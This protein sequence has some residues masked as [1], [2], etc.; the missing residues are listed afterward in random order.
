MSDKLTITNEIAYNSTFRSEKVRSQFDI[1]PKNKLTNS[2]TLD[3]SLPTKWTIGAIAGPSGSGKT[4]LAKDKFTDADLFDGTKPVIDWPENKSII[5]GFPDSESV[6]DITESLSRVGFSSPPHWLQPYHTLST[7][8]RFRVDMARLLIENSDQISIVDEFTS[9]VDRDVAK[10]ISHATAKY[11]RANS[12]TFVACSCHYDILNWLEPDWVVDLETEEVFTDPPF[13]K[14][15]IEIEVEPVE[16]SAWRLFQDHHYLD[17]SLNPSTQCYVGYWD[18]NPV[19]FVGVIHFPHKSTSKFKR[20]TRFVTLPPFQGLGIGTNVLNSV[21]DYYRREQKHRI[22]IVTSHPGLMYTLNKSVKWRV[23]DS[24]T[25]NAKHAGDSKKQSMNKT[26][27][28][29]RKTATFEY[30]GGHK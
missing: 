15:Q 13:Q 1:Q 26:K 10:S 9:T 23:I 16:R 30:D 20:V 24:Y 18:N 2:I 5:D 29:R 12:Q 21:C 17:K 6:Q 28:S 3:W 11:A 25:R 7:G 19:T 27:S 14:P 22:T 4:T 8:Q